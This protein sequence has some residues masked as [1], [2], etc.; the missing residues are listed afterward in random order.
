[1]G[2]AGKNDRLN[3]Q[4]IKQNLCSLNKIIKNTKYLLDKSVVM[5]LNYK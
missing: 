1:M 3:A 5:V 4:K 2:G